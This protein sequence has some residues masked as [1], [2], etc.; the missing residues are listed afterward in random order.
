MRLSSLGD[1][2]FSFGDNKDVNALRSRLGR[3]FS[4]RGGANVDGD[5]QKSSNK[6]SSSGGISSSSSLISSM[7]ARL[8]ALEKAHRSMTDQLAEKEAEA[9][10]LRAKVTALEAVAS[11][12]YEEAMTSLKLENEKLKQDVAGMEKFLNDYG[13]Q[14]VGG[15]DSSG[16]SAGV[17]AA[18]LV[19]RLKLLSDVAGD[20]SG[21]SV[22]KVGR[23]AR[24]SAAEQ[25]PVSVFADGILIRRGPFR[26]F[27]SDLGKSFA[28]DV[29][30]G[31]FPSEFKKRYPHGVA[32]DV[33]DRSGE[34]YS[35][36]S[37]DHGRTHRIGGDSKGAPM[38]K[39][40]FLM[41]LPKSVIS[42]GGKVVDVRSSLGKVLSGPSSH[43]GPSVI[44][45]DTPIAKAI[46][47]AESLDRPSTPKDL[48]TLHVRSSDGKTVLILKMRS[49][50]TVGDVVSAIVSQGMEESKVSF[51]LR[52]AFPPCEYS[53][54][55]KTLADA[56]LTPSAK[57]MI[58][59]RV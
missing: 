56:G 54:H 5:G 22:V 25:I 32:F 43:G 14:W 9:M 55:T 15:R 21:K 57:L 30:D 1:E 16:S 31:F 58:R 17:D 50:D 11:G 28:V 36:S 8:T 59:R 20:G 37:T 19:E 29:L 41:R 12:D 26:T 13:L 34:V 10:A 48:T 42:A 47:E 53:D 27:E 6:R 23:E 35:S 44:V 2:N 24:F 18:L 46:A 4:Y 49:T 52:T 33:T 7:A 40:E 39:E 38:S 51:T 45:A 3:D